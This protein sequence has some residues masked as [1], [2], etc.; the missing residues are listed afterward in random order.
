[1]RA[2]LL[3]A[4]GG[5]EKVEIRDVPKPVITPDEVLVEV[6]AAS[7]NPVDFKIRDGKLKALLQ[8]PLPMIMGC[9]LSGVVVETGALV[10]G[11]K[12]G[13][14]IYARL[15]KRRIGA[16]ADFAPVRESDLAKKPK[17]LSHVEAASIPLVGLTARQALVDKGGMSKGAKVLVH[18]GAGG[19][20]TFAIQYAKAVGAIVATT[21]SAANVPLVKSLGADIAIDYHSTRF[22]DVLKDQD[23]VLD[24]VGGE[25]L[26]RS[27]SVIRRGGRVVSIAGSPEPE[28]AKEWGFGPLMQLGTWFLSRKERAAAK[29][30][31][32]TYRFLFMEPNG[33]QL[34]EIAGLLERGAIKP[35]IDKTFPL[36]QVKDA[37]AY[38][39]TGRARGKIVLTLG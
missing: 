16:W 22:E 11:V 20:G 38:S 28:F 29:K 12:A 5:P 27:F 32:A 36:E 2:V 19:V 26:L 13:D 25:T 31:G 17:N 23:V 9:D 33:T 21:C 6:K 4:Y 35:V 3:T 8:P 39:E 37:L 34:S 15:N 18:A 30:A 24:G 14:E 7:V 1:M 10:K